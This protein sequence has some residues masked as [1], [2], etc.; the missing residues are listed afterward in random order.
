MILWIKNSNSARI[1]KKTNENVKRHVFLDLGTNNGD[2][3]KFF[4]DKAER[5]IEQS[6]LKGYGALDNKKWEIYAIEANPYFNKILTD[7][8]VYCENLG[9]K[10][11]LLT[12]TAAWTKN[13]KLVFYLDTVNKDYDFWGSS[14]IKDHPDVISS[15]YKNVTVNGIDISEI[16]KKY[17]SDDEIVMKI[18]IE[19]AEYDLL[20]HLIKEGSLHL[21]DIIAIEYHQRMLKDSIKNSENLQI[22]FKQYFNFFN[23]KFIQWW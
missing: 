11:N 1:L 9:H 15:G 5:S 17:N 12:E 13:E 16:L 14:L 3:V 21:V 2:S 7:V 20:L 6:Y 18:D 8:K 22:F 23:V 19:G 10:F 4:V